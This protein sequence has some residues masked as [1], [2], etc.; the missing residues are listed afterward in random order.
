MLE[1][2]AHQ[3]RPIRNGP[4]QIS[5][6]YKVE[7]FLECPRLFGVVDFELDICRDPVPSAAVALFWVADLLPGRLS[8]AQVCPNDL[9][10]WIIV[11][12]LNGPDTCPGSKVKDF[13]RFVANRSKKKLVAHRYANQLMHEVETI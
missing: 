7:H 10:T 2:L 6:V 4:R 11:A 8:G 3:F 12:H 13:C 9:G 5:H 1:S